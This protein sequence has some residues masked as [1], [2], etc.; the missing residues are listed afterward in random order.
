MYYC[1]IIGRIFKFVIL[2]FCDP[3]KSFQRFLILILLCIKQLNFIIGI[4]TESEFICFTRR[5]FVNL[6]TGL[7]FLSVL[8]AP[9]KKKESHQ[10]R[11]VSTVPSTVFLTLGLEVV[12]SIQCPGQ[13]DN[14]K[15][16]SQR[17]VPKQ[18]WYSI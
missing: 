3:I 8:R 11:R 17:L 13:V 9:K 15:R 12:C 2:N 7:S 18:P 10:K 4:D 5:K 1:C 6:S 14:L 16:D